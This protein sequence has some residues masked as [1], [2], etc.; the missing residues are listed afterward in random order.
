VNT[1][2][3]NH[4]YIARCAACPEWI[5]HC[6]QAPF[7]AERVARKHAKHQPGH[8][9]YVVDVSSLNVVHRYR[10]D[11]IPALGADSMPPF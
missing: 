7:K 2:P 6:P 9:A 5:E 4:Y 8:E 11:A 1:D 10:Y 3:R